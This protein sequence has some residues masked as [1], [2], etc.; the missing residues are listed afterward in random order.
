MPTPQKQWTYASLMVI[1]GQRQLKPT[2]VAF[3]RLHFSH[4]PRLQS[5][6]VEILLSNGNEHQRHLATILPHDPDAT[7]IPIRL[8]RMM[9]N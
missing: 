6:T 3:D 2:H 8:A 7:Q 1:D 4:P 9:E 5:A